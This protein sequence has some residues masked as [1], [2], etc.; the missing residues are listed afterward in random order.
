M[1]GESPRISL[2]RLPNARETLKR[3]F[4][5]SALSPAPAHH[6][7]ELG[8]VDVVH[9]A[10]LL[11]QLALLGRGDHAHGVG[12][13][14][15]AELG[16]E[17]A[18]AAGG[19]PDQHGLAGLELHAGDEHPVG[20]EVHEPVGG[21]LRPGEAGGLGKQL[22][23]L[24]LRELG[25]RA[26][27]GLVAP[28]L[29]AGGGQRIEPVHLG[30]L[31]GGL[32]AVGDDLV[33]GLP[34]RHARA[35]LPD[36]PGSVG[37][38]DVVAVLRVVAV[39]HDRHGLA[40]GGPDVVVVHAR[41]H[42]PHDH[43]EGAGLRHLDLLELEGVAW[44]AEPLLADHPRGHRRGAA[45]PA[46]RRAGWAWSGRSGPSVLSVRLRAGSYRRPPA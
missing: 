15:L 7:L 31:V 30:I 34:A 32:V 18:Q 9:R 35:D 46:P 16:G 11:H 21:R 37:A 14:D 20:G 45:R 3:S 42:H 8:P 4:S 26:P 6:P 38:P 28:D 5:S 19:P 25:E 29:L 1:S 17:H 43:L 2:T 40:E 12:P 13:G 36:D 41:G 23:G 10:Q 39:A 33:A 27:G 22:L 44:L 24:D